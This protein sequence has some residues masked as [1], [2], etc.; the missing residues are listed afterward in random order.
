MVKFCIG[1]WSGGGGPGRGVT[2][3][4]VRG[5]GGPLDCGGAWGRHGSA[6]P[7]DMI[8]MLGN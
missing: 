8:I 1:T 4:E 2:V 6:L 5:S 3:D 7:D